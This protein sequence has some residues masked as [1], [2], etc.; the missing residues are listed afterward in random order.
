[1]PDAGCRMTML[2]DVKLTAGS[3]SS[4]LHPASR[5]RGTLPP[6]PGTRAPASAALRG[7]CFAAVHG[8]SHR[9]PRTQG[10]GAYTHDGSVI[11][12]TT[13]QSRSRSST[14]V[15]GPPDE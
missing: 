1:M 6:A 11:R 13:A 7:T 9:T 15:R 4:I 2:K 14:R 10:E 8:G 12:L 5:I 3:T